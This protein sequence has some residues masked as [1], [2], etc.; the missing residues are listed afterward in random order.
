MKKIKI[1]VASI[2]LSLGM[3]SLANAQEISKQLNDA[4]GQPNLVV[5]KSGKSDTPFSARS[6]VDNKSGGEIFKK[7]LKFDDK[8]TFNVIKTRSTK[9]LTDQKYQQYYKGIKVEFS[10]YALHLSDGNLTSINGS[11]LAIKDLDVTPSVAEAQALETAKLVSLAKKFVWE[12]PEFLG[13]KYTK[14][15]AE[16]VVFPQNVK[17]VVTG[18][19]AYKFDIYSVDPLSRSNIYINAKTG[20]YLYK[21][22]IIKHVNDAKPKVGAE[23]IN[24][25]PATT[26]ATE[27]KL[28]LFDVGTAET[29]YVGT[30]PITTTKNADGQFIL[31]DAT[32]GNGIVTLNAN[33]LGNPNTGEVTSYV[34]EFTD[35]DNNWTAAEH[36]NSEIRVQSTQAL[37][38]H[39]GAG[40]IYDYWKAVRNRNSWDDNGAQIKSYVHFADRLDNA[41]WT[42]EYMIYG[43]GTTFKPLTA[44]DVSAHEIGHAIATAEANLAYKGEN[45]AINE[46][47]SDIWGATIEYYA[48][49]DKKTWVIGEDIT[50]DGLGLRSM[51]SPKLHQQPDTY[52]G[53]YWEDADPATCSDGN[54]HCGV[55]T[56]SGVINHFYYILSQG[57]TGTNDVGSAYNVTGIGIDKASAIVYRA[58]SE[59]LTSEPTF[60]EFR[61][62]LIQSA[63]DLYGANS[64]EAQTVAASLYAVNIGNPVDTQSPTDP[65]NLAAAKIR[66][67]SV[68]LKWDAST[69][70]YT[71]A[72]YKV[73][74]GGV[75]LTDVASNTTDVFDL[76]TNTAYQ[77]Y[78]KAFDQNGNISN[79]SNV[80]NVTTAAQ[81]TDTE[82]P[83]AP[84]LSLAKTG[85]TS[86]DINW[87]KSTDND[88]VRAYD[89][90]VDNQKFATAPAADVAKVLE[91]VTANTVH[92][93][94][95]K[96]FD[97]E[98]NYS[99]N[100]NVVSTKTFAGD[101][102][103]PQAVLMTQNYLVVS[104]FHIANIDMAADDP[105][106]IANQNS[107]NYNFAD[108]VVKLKAGQTYNAKIGYMS[109]FGGAIQMRMFVWADYN[110]DG[111]FN[112]F[113]ETLYQSDKNAGNKVFEFSF[114]V[115]QDAS[116]DYDSALRVGFMQDFVPGGLYPNTYNLPCGQLLGFNGFSNFGL[117]V[118]KYM[119]TND[120]NSQ[121]KLASIYPN[122]AT[123][124]V[125]V[126]K[127]KA[128]DVYTVYSASG[129]RVSTGAYST[130]INVAKLPAGVYVLTMDQNGVKTNAKFIKK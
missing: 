105:D 64:T 19:L 53:Q 119:A 51:Q 80:V 3:V 70:N 125:H 56:N 38:A 63:T 22:A 113:T 128:S 61:E 59:Y 107:Y 116:L 94:Y 124:V 104:E 91:P 30:K 58:E 50:A 87:I 72:G 123:D 12:V 26:T 98:N 37:D 73:Y 32:R 96:A 102:C 47:L 28:T 52:K 110:R 69:D 67:T 33:S 109:I 114:T 115:P 55:H 4:K 43:D 7:F 117:Q 5:F 93:V 97:F 65:L 60:M 1:T 77:F 49:P 76:A 85:S 29:L 42:G 100:S 54:D 81:S 27:N 18:V 68:R 106:L 13:Q 86:I 46:A 14:P 40:E 9:N 121:N 74:K 23:V 95:L 17:G 21:N 92:Q 82:K 8:T 16:L 122:P 89:I 44:F 112:P 108:K 6:I 15:K 35:N 62:M 101:Y 130:G 34:T 111:V 90:Y 118:E 57:K 36:N 10:T 83:T 20:E 31:H 48:L 127:A 129:N 88:E 25:P 2:C 24:V 126:E 84:V 99:D 45:G 120:V 11:F 71:V 75:F 78:V 103:L 66:S 41:A 79:S 39:W